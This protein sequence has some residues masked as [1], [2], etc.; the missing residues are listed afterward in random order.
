M[1]T[2]P[3]PRTAAAEALAKANASKSPKPTPTPK[4]TS[5][6]KPS[7]NPTPKPKPSSTSTGTTVVPVVGN[8]NQL[9]AM[10]TEPTTDWS[11]FTDGTLVLNS[12][13][14]TGGV[15]ASPYVS[16]VPVK[17]GQPK[18]V[19]ILPTADGTGYYT[20]DLDKIVQ[21]SLTGVTATNMQA[22]KAQL[23]AYYTSDKEFRL[24]IASPDKD[25]A[26]QNAIKRAMSEVSV[27]NFNAGT[28]N[29]AAIAK[30]PNAP[31]PSALYTFDSYVM[32][33]PQVATPTSESARSSGLT[34]REDALA[35]FYRT[36]QQYVG[37]PALVNNLPTLAEAYWNKLH[38]TELNRQSTSSS[39][40]DIF[41]NRSSSTT[42]YVQLSNED[43]LEM[44]IGF[45]TKGGSAKDPKTGKTATS[46]GIKGVDYQKL[47]DTGGLIGD[48]YTKLLEHSYEMGVPVNKEDLVSR[49]AKALLP[50]GSVDAQMKSLTQASK[51][52]YKNLTPYIDS[53]L[54]VSD[55]ASYYQK[56]RD[57]ELELAAGTT[58]IFDDNVQK[59]INGEKL[60]DQNDYLLGIRTDPNW[61]FT[62]K[63]NESSAGFIDAILKT[64]GKV[65]M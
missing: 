22:Y 4:P 27:S 26:F 1:T 20:Q 37:D 54:K 47:Q 11:K 59:A 46:T 34:T 55:I 13:S 43:R 49:S 56:T 57:S 30:N 32:S 41:G 6:A 42:A 50:G 3:D 38:A 12:G 63:A 25:V 17:G 33:R 58:D 31:L 61:R 52:Y 36:V 51:A 7:S 65:G 45:I 60:M 53:G 14:T 16:M 44:R 21:A 39:T 24:S 2:P 62:K 28:Q 10:E 5:T 40:T 15:Q 64:W 35:E 29:A 18:A 9:P 48:N 8:D 23:R 19:V